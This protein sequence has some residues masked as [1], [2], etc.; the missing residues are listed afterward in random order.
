M[1]VD[2]PFTLESV[3]KIIPVRQWILAKNLDGSLT[4]TLHNHQTGQIQEAEGYQFDRGDLVQM[5]FGS[6]DT[7]SH[8][9]K[10]GEIAAV[11]TSNMLGEQLNLLKTELAVQEANRG[12]VATG[13]KQEVIRQLEEELNLA[14]ENLKLQKKTYDRAKQ[15]Y[16]EGVIPLAELELAENMHES[17]IL[18]VNVAENALKVAQTGEKQ[19]AVSLADSQI[20]SLR[21]QI[22]YLEEKATRYTLTA[23]F[24]GV[25]RAESTL[26]GDRILLE[27]TSAFVLFIPIRIRD[28][29]FIQ[30]GNQIEIELPDNH[31]VFEST[32]LEVGKQV[33]ILSREQVV[34]VK[35][36][37]REKRLPT[38][39]LLQTSVHCGKVRVLEFLKR[40]VRW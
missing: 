37:T 34:I 11:I 1:P 13:E 39:I 30:P 32:V 20:R 17:A 8:F 14:K 4:V 40:S 25:V 15:L 21:E 23:P 9:V 29:R 2:I 10:A 22:A 24:P 5:Q 26:E 36:L 18:Q 19:E 6:G 31:T 27:D 7:S 38:G 35:A 33:V 12:V 3:A 16:D 28:S